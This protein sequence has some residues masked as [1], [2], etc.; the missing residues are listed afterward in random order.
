[1]YQVKELTDLNRLGEIYQ[2][3]V[4]AYEHSDQKP[5][6]NSSTFPE[7]FYDEV[8]AKSSHFIIENGDKIIACARLIRLESLSQI[9]YYNL[10]P[11]VL[12]PSRSSFWYYSRIAIHPDYRKR[13]LSSLMDN[14]IIGQLKGQ[15]NHVVILAKIKIQ[16]YRNN[17][18]FQLIET[19]TDYDSPD[20]PFSKQQPTQLLIKNLSE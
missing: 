12:S 2:L 16:H 6:I 8:D 10:K 11:R 13:G 7:G 4:N 9:P 3:R 15:E 18:G 17:Y 19:I 1:M 20:Y 5:Y 14:Y